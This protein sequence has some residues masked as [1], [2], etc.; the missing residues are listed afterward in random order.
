MSLLVAGAGCVATALANAFDDVGLDVARW[1]RSVRPPDGARDVVIVA[2]TDSAIAE[3][4]AQLVAEGFVGPSTILLHCAGALPAEEVFSSLRMH[5]AGVG[6]L[7]PLRALA[8]ADEDRNLIG[9]VFG[10]EGDTVGIEAAVDLARRV[11]GRPLVLTAEGLARYHAAAALVGNHTLALVAA[12]VALLVAEGLDP[13]AAEAA[14]GGL[15][16]SVARNVIAR[17]LPDALTGAIARGDVAV[18]AR[19]LSALE[20]P[21]RSIY[22]A[23][24]LPTVDLARRT[25]RAPVEALAAL[26]ALLAPHRN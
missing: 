7:H 3:V 21:E 6:L 25:G 11:G 23:S 24:A 20:E 4:A 5:V 12:G 15:L 22:R 10:V 2:V 18:V 17:G 1:S 16:A 14:L 13:K 9:T 19:H 8:G 26:E